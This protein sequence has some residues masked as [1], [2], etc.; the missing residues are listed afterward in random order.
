VLTPDRKPYEG[1]PRYVLKRN[2]ERAKKMGVEMFVGP[3]LEFFYFKDSDA[4]EVLDKGGY[5]DLT[6]LD[7]ATITRERETVFALEKMG[8][9]SLGPCAELNRWTAPPF[10]RDLL[11]L[12]PERELVQ[13]TRS[14]V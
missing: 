5:F 14:R 10:K 7:L 12:C 8:I 13:A 2:L 3:E 6:P 1:D 11:C 4:P 9:R